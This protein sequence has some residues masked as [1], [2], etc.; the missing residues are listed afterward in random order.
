M[1]PLFPS[2]RPSV[3]S[4]ICFDVDQPCDDESELREMEKDYDAWVGETI[5]A[6]LFIIFSWQFF[7]E[8]KI[9]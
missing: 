8:T 9:K 2:L 3:S 6:T 7:F 5:D 4:S 1:I